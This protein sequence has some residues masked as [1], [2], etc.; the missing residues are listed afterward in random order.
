VKNGAWL[1]IGPY[2]T[3]IRTL[4]LSGEANNECTEFLCIKPFKGIDVYWK[5]SELPCPSHAL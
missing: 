5:P 4:G 2:L 1:A 3:A